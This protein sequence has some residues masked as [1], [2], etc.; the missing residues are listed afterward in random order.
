MTKVIRLM[1]AS[2]GLDQV[3]FISDSSLNRDEEQRQAD[4]CFCLS[5]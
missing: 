5:T 4:I 3:V 2:D 1:L